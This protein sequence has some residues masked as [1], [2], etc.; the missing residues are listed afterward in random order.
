[1]NGTENCIKADAS[2]K[3]RDA[4]SDVF[5]D[6]RSSE[7]LIAWAPLAILPLVVILVVPAGLP[8]WV[9]MWLMAG[10]I[11]WAAKWLSWRLALPEVTAT[12]LARKLLWWVLWPGMDPARFIKTEAVPRPNGVDWLRGFIMTLVGAALFYA[13]GLL[14]GRGWVLLGAWAAMFA[15]AFVLH[16]GTFHII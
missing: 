4:E 9:V 12:P 2:V 14:I 16:Y 7:L 3:G 10:A 5:V 8:R 11:Y 15:I 13:G 6:R 1:M